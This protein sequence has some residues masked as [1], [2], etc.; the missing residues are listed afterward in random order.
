MGYQQFPAEFKAAAVKMVVEQKV[1]AREASANLGIKLSTL[2]HWV[3]QHRRGEGPAKVQEDLRQQVRRMQAEIDQ[4]R[5][6]RD[7]LKKA[8]AYFA[9]DQRP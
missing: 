1:S 5:M 9:R 2:L 3:K 6:E 7:I 4:L 8:A